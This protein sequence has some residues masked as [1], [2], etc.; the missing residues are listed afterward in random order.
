MGNA[1]KESHSAVT[2]PDD[3]I[4]PP[5]DLAEAMTMTVAQLQ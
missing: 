3:G 4:R 1:S 5:G 2:V